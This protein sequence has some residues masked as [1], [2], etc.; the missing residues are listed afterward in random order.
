MIAEDTSDELEHL[1][2]SELRKSP[3]KVTAESPKGDKI[4]P[5]KQLFK[6]KVQEIMNMSQEVETPTNKSTAKKGVNLVDSHIEKLQKK[7]KKY[8]EVQKQ[9]E[10]E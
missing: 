9:R 6:Q 4:T 1:G 7:L 3:T 10:E 8:E 2:T 5:M